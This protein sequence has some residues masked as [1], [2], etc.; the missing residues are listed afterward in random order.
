MSRTLDISKY[1]FIS[2]YIY[3]HTH[4]YYMHTQIYTQTHFNITYINTY[5]CIYL[6]ISMIRL[7]KWKH[8]VFFYEIYLQ[9]ESANIYVKNF[10]ENIFDFVV[11]TSVTYAWMCSVKAAIKHQL[12]H[13]IVFE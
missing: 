4:I 3:I 8:L 11:K 9:Q 1:K 7:A 6:F 5:V 2:L 10:I 12:M 13:G